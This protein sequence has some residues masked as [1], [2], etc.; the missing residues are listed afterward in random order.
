MYKQKRYFFFLWIIALLFFISGC[1]PKDPL[2]A[3]KSFASSYIDVPFIAPRSELCA[4]TSLEMVSS[5]WQNVTSYTPYLSRKDLDARTLIPSK[6]GTLQIELVATARANGLLV[7]P[8][9][10]TL[11]AMFSELAHHHPVIVLVNRAYSWYPLWHYSPVT[12]YDAQTHDVLTHF[13]DKADEAIPVKTFAALWRRSQNWGVVLL[14]PNELPATFN[15]KTYLKAAYEL[16]KTGMV[17]EAI[18]A[19][20]NVLLHWPDNTDFLFALANSYYRLKRIPEAENS[21]RQLLSLESTHPLAINNLADLLC[22]TRRSAEAI[23][24]LDS[25]TTDDPG[26]KALIEATRK[27]VLKGCD[28]FL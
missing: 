20:K 12:G 18:A 27:D 14:P 21:Y 22:H 1:A 7:Y 26:V 19:Y 8:L 2:P 3:G 6:K 23:K 17:D 15:P 28:P 24:L 10:P 5:Y 9:D 13:S 4:S 25:V 11:E 16:E